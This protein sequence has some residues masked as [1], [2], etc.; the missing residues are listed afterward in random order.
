MKENDDRTEIAILKE[1]MKVIQ[2][3]IQEIKIDI[4]TIVSQLNK[5]PS[6]EAE[7]I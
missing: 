7:I 6:L 2:A 5:Q 1:Q 3:D 4:K